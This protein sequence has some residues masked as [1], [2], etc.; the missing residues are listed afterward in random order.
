VRLRRLADAAPRRPEFEHLPIDVPALADGWSEELRL[1]ATDWELCPVA[2]VIVDDPA[3]CRAV[4]GGRVVR[5]GAVV[6]THEGP[7][8]VLEVL[9][10]GILYER[11]GDADLVPYP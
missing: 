10:A 7:A 11:D 8:R 5:A 9:D 1:E 4:V 2:G 3:A 6:E